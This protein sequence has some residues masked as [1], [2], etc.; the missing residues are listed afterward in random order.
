MSY[1][2]EYQER[3]ERERKEERDYEGDAMYEIWRSGGNTDRIDY[4]R[5]REH[6]HQGDSYEAAARDELRH[7]RPKQH[8]D[9][10]PEGQICGGCGCP[11]DPQTGICGCNPYDA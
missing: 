11:I 6:H 4:D 9:E 10:Q 7:Q 8:E 2:D 3:R 1:G 5:V